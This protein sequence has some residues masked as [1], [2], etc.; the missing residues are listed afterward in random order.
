LKEKNGSNLFYLEKKEHY[1]LFDESK[2]S[3]IITRKD[4]QSR[5]DN[6]VLNI[7]PKA[8]CSGTWCF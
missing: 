3:T 8:E 2:K 1:H 4:L 5:W 6:L 7:I